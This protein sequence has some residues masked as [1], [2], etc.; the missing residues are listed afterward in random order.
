MS[1]RITLTDEDIGLLIS[2]LDSYHVNGVGL[3]H[4]ELAD[5]AAKQRIDQ[6]R[7]KLTTELVTK[8]K[9]LLMIPRD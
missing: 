7:H 6:I 9:G 4:Y 3:K 1:K 2:A 8:P 5:L